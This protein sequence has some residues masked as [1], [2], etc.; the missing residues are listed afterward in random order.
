MKVTVFG[1]I[2]PIGQELVEDLLFRGY[3]VIALVADA[4]QVPPGWGEDV[5]VVLGQITDPAAV[6]AAMDGAEAVINTVDPR[7]RPRSR[8]PGLVEATGHIVA[9]M[10]RHGI[11]RYI[12][13]GTPL[14]S[15]CPKEKPTTRLKIHRFLARHLDPHAY[16]Q[17]AGMLQVVAGSGL[18]WTIVRFLHVTGGSARGLKYVGFFGPGAVGSSATA[19]DIAR[20][21]ATQILETAYIRDAPAVSN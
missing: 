9:G 6:D 3:E 21:T 5:R 2:S 14:V 15:L 8:R 17:M 16:R 13:H 7:L 11:R 18:D 1:A 4:T 19:A 20:F 10:H 12:G